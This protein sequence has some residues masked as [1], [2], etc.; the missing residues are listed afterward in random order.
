MKKMEYIIKT[1]IL[2]LNNAN[3]SHFRVSIGEFP[4]TELL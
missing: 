3:G 2:P 4:A 1:L